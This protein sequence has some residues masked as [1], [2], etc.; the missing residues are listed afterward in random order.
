V[1]TLFISDL[2]LDESRPHIVDLF[3]RFLANEASRANAL[4]ILG[5][6]SKA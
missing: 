6:C 5:D 1:R 3:V 2:H 4:Y